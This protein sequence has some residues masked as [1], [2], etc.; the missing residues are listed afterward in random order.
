MYL[1]ATV[2]FEFSV[3][4]YI[5]LVI[6]KNIYGVRDIFRNFC[7][8]NFFITRK[9]LFVP[10]N[11]R[12]IWV[13]RVKI[14]QSGNFQ[15]HL[16]CPRYFPKFLYINFFLKLENGFLYLLVIVIFEFSVSKYIILNYLYIKNFYSDGG[17]APKARSRSQTIDGN[18]S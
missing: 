8:S 17:W 10:L 6:F 2:I 12:H 11:Y 15:K 18:P 9:R 1:L 4:K 16:W 14:H 13:Q 3:S 7:I 5:S